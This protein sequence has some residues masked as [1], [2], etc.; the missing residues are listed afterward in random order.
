MYRAAPPLET[1]RTLHPARDEERRSLT[2]RVAADH[3][4]LDLCGVAYAGKLV[5]HGVVAHRS[6]TWMFR[7]PG[8]RL[9][10]SYVPS[11]TTPGTQTPAQPAVAERPAPQ[12]R[13]CRQGPRPAAGYPYSHDIERHTDMTMEGRATSADRRNDQAKSI[14]RGRR[15][16]VVNGTVPAPGLHPLAP[17]E[18]DDQAR[19]MKRLKEYISDLAKSDE[20]QGADKLHPFSCCRRTSSSQHPPAAGPIPTTRR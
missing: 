14:E 10:R 16:T 2:D 13:P 11:T 4:D 3:R 19:H 5:V 12:G 9:D 17:N 20:D 7:R 6:A 15:D 18:P 1:R 8:H